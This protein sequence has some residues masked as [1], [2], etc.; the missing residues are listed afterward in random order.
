MS[1]GQV[2]QPVFKA[3]HQRQAMLLP[4]SLEELIT[5]NHPVRVVDEVLGKINIQ[6]MIQK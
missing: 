2:F 6:P 3:Y 1:K 5:V 4:T